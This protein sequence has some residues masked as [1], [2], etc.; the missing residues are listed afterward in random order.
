MYSLSEFIC[1]SQISHRNRERCLCS[2]VTLCDFQTISKS[3]MWELIEKANS[4]TLH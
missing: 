4:Q 2:V 1:G 3:F